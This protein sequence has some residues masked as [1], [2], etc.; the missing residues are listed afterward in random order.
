VWEWCWDWG[1]IYESGYQQNPKGP[2]SGKYRVL[3]GGS[4]YN[5]PSSVRAANRADNNPTKRNLN[6]GFRC[7]RTF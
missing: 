2:V 5:N 1:A 4:W 3:R 7:A 6:V